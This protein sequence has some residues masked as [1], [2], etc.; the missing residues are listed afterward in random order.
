[1]KRVR[2]A[3]MR[4]RREAEGG[5]K[6][7]LGALLPLL[8]AIVAAVHTA[9][10][11][12]TESFWPPRRH[13]QRI[14]ALPELGTLLPIRR[15]V[16]ARPTG[17]AAIRSLENADRRHADPQLVWVGRMPHDGVQVPWHPYDREG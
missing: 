10:V 14:H 5:R 12:L 17:L 2:V 16:A 11:L 13:H 4:R 9:M 8:A 15:I 3:R 6:P 7:R 1:M